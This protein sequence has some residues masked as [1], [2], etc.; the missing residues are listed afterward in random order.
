MSDA[1]IPSLSGEEEQSIVADDGEADE[2]ETIVFTFNTKLKM[3]R[4]LIP[5]LIG[6]R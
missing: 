6:A 1:A 3:S 5:A 4:A 2:V